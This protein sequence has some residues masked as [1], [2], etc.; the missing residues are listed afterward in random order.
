MKKVNKV[1]N[2]CKCGKIF[3]LYKVAYNKDIKLGFYMRENSKKD[4]INA[5]E[6]NLPNRIYYYKCLCGK[7]YYN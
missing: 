6:L 7:E 2:K 4:E 1:V 5:K 3:S